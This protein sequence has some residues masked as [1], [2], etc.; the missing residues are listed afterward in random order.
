M[1]SSKNTRHD[2]NKEF[3]MGNTHINQDKKTFSLQ[4]FVQ[5]VITTPHPD[6]LFAACPRDFSLCDIQPHP[7]LQ[8][9]IQAI[10]TIRDNKVA[11][12]W[13]Y[14][15]CQEASFFPWDNAPDTDLPRL[16]GNIYRR[17]QGGRTS[18]SF[19]PCFDMLGERL[20]ALSPEKRAELYASDI[21]KKITEDITS[22]I[23]AWYAGKKIDIFFYDSSIIASKK[24]EKKRWNPACKQWRGGSVL[25]FLTARGTT[26]LTEK[27]MAYISPSKIWST[28]KE[29]AVAG[30][31]EEHWWKKDC[32][33]HANLHS[34]QYGVLSIAASNGCP[35]NFEP[36]YEDMVWGFE[37]QER[38]SIFP[39][40]MKWYFRQKKGSVSLLEEK[41]NNVS[42]TE[43]YAPIHGHVQFP[44]F[45]D[46]WQNVPDDTSH[47]T[48]AY[49]R[50]QH[51][52]IRSVIGPRILTLGA[53]ENSMRGIIDTTNPHIRTVAHSIL[54]MPV[55]L[56]EHTLTTFPGWIDTALTSNVSGQCKD[57]I[58]RTLANTLNMRLWSRN[59]DIHMQDLS[60]EK[61]FP[62]DFLLRVSLFWF[63]T[64][65]LPDGRAL[66][67]NFLRNFC[68][69][70]TCVTSGNIQ[71]ED[72][73]E[74]LQDE[75]FDRTPVTHF[76]HTLFPEHPI[77]LFALPNLRHEINTF[78]PGEFLEFDPDI[79]F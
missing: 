59:L 65:T 30:K 48:Q 71:P 42:D 10:Y 28:A 45:L 15:I 14:K 75:I 27:E 70:M 17:A 4:D 68:T 66:R 73:M 47:T 46:T 78:I 24:Q 72:I 79:I 44:S 53:T 49:M 7:L 41:I 5:K 40:K 11:F 25:R 23:D 63:T 34:P 69:S 54:Q 29:R 20:S 62:N 74:K 26:P 39:F 50:R 64:Q 43:L 76:I 32:T 33:F 51:A 16:I 67:E 38:K 9:F 58:I 61:V 36:L 2:K 3:F 13:I 52:H 1:G 37:G 35:G 8:Y 56:N 12:P 19:F 22:I 60:K 57:A 55:H 31:L 77:S 18:C 6:T 21:D